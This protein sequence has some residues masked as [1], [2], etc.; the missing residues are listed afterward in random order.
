MTDDRAKRREEALRRNAAE[1][2]ER[3]RQLRL[4]ADLAR[5]QR[6]KDKEDKKKK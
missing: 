4:A 1:R 3:E 6:V 5:A 2:K